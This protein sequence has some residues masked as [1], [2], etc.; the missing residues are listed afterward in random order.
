MGSCYAHLEQKNEAMSVKK[1]QKV[2]IINLSS[3]DLSEVESRL[4][5][6]LLTESD[7]KIMALFVVGKGKNYV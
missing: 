7:K 2:D 1:K 4:T 5:S 6:G 3:N